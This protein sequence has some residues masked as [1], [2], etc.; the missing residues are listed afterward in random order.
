MPR[1]VENKDR[2][3]DWAEA[4]RS[5]LLVFPQCLVGERGLG[6]TSLRWTG[7]SGGDAY[8]FYEE[9][10]AVEQIKFLAPSSN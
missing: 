6:A 8:S 2:S 3:T 9:T 4:M 7:K 1:W 10:A 5:N